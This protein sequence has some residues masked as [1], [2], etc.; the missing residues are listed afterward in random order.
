[1]V[2]DKEV[3]R[4]DTWH[5]YLNGAEVTEKQYRAVYPEIQP[6]PGGTLGVDHPAGWP[7]VSKLGFGIH[8][9]KVAMA[10]AELK[11]NGITG[12][13]YQ[14]DGSCKIDNS[15]ARRKLLKIRGEFCQDSY[16]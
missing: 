8:K 14:P 7:M 15:E 11:K 9:R 2:Q 13:V 4:G 16:Y 6:L 3:L 12:V 10:N 5:F 1:M